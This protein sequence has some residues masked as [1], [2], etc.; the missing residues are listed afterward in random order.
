MYVDDAPIVFI[1]LI[2]FRLANAVSLNVFIINI[3]AANPM[4]TANVVAEN[5]RV[6]VKLNSLSI[7][8]PDAL[9]SLTAALPSILSMISW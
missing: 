9:I 6:L 8:S 7:A 5:T 2:S 4:R 3:N 1:I